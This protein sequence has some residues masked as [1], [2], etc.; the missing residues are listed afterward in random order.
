MPMLLFRHALAALRVLAFS[1]LGLLCQGAAQGEEPPLA[2]GYPAT[3]A[4]AP[5]QLAG[6][7]S[8]TPSP[9]ETAPRAPRRSA[10]SVEPAGAPA[11]SPVAVADPPPAPLHVE[12]A[13]AAA[14]AHPAPSADPPLVVPSHP[15]PHDEPPAPTEAQRAEFLR[16]L[17]LLRAGQRTQ[18]WAAAEGL[19]AYLLYPYLLF[20]DL[21]ARL[22]TATTDEVR[23]F[24]ASTAERFLTEQLRSLWLRRLAKEKRDAEFVADYRPQKDLDLQ[25]HHLVLHIRAA[26]TAVHPELEQAHLDEA[27]AI[28]LSKRSLPSDCD[29]AFDT[30]YQSALITPDLIWWRIEVAVEA[31]NYKLAAHLAQRL[32]AEDRPWVDL[33]L[34]NI[35]NPRRAVGR[36]ELRKDIP[37]ARRILGYYIGQLARKKAAEAIALWREA[38]RYHTF[39]PA[40]AAPVAHRIAIEALL[41][42]LPGVMDLLDALPPEALDE[43]IQIA[44][45]QRALNARDWARIVRYTEHPAKEGVDPLRWRYWRARALELGGHPA[46]AHK[47]YKALARERDYYGFLAADRLNLRYEMHHVPIQVEEKYFH[48]TEERSGIRAAREWWALGDK[49]MARQAWLFELDSMT[50]E[51]QEIAALVAYRMGWYDMTITT[52]GKAASHDDLAL[53]FPLPYEEL[54]AAQ[55]VTRGMNPAFIYGIMRAESTFREDV[56][57]PVGAVGL[58][59]LMPGT[60]TLT[61]RDTGEPYNGPEDLVQ[62]RINIALGTAYLHLML[63]KFAHNE[64]M[65]AAA[66]NAGP[67]RVVKWRPEAGCVAADLWIDTIPFKE[68]RTY[69]RRVLYNATIYD[70][71]LSK[72]VIPLHQRVGPIAA[73]SIAHLDGCKDHI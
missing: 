67:G 37:Q 30:L 65:A 34:Q 22:D 4:V 45:L 2:P 36:P 3:A 40:E 51:D 23:G 28:W 35:G 50:R 20:A 9:A 21:K 29:P 57:S 72:K 25:C 38:R 63:T 12:P 31:G 59:Q 55:A 33:W 18:A 26:A 52:L 66:Y 42:E 43:Q 13:H 16:A 46:D 60:A 6:T 49:A 73:P 17:A 58:M 71:R 70:W 69:V 10:E 24:L 19:R 15:A 54:V 27:K 68:T 32:A 8:P 7:A 48:A 53:R 44:Q 61:A 5:P 39:T 47:L 62:P 14:V 11:V 56:R 64:A 1:G 41:Q